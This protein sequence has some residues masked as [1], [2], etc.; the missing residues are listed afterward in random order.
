MISEKIYFLCYND[1][2]KHL[3]QEIFSFPLSAQV[4]LAP[5]RQFYRMHGILNLSAAYFHT[6]TGELLCLKS[7]AISFLWTASP[8]T[9]I[10]APCTISERS[11]ITGRTGLKSLNWQGLTRSK[12]MSAG[13]C[14]SPRPENSISAVCST[15]SALLKPPPV[16]VFTVL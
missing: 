7:K 12:P 1:L 10:R 8:L 14:T 9:Y 4:T 11:P 5:I 3:G 2:A 15:L 13:I 6:V 16:W